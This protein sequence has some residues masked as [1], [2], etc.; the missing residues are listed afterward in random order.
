MIKNSAES[1]P[2]SADKR[3]ACSGQSAEKQFSVNNNGDNFISNFNFKP[4]FFWSP[5]T[6]SWLSSYGLIRFLV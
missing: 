5:N 2:V 6:K 3:L 1:P 4:H